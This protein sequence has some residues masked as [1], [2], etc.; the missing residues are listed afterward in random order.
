MKR[1]LHPSPRGDCAKRCNVVVSIVELFDQPEATE[2]HCNCARVVLVSAH[3]KRPV[4]PGKN[5]PQSSS[6][7]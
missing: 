1:I 2:L 3:L 7:D 6:A 4:W 5:T